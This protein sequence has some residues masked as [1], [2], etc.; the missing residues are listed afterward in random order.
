MDYVTGRPAVPRRVQTIRAY[1]VFQ[2]HEPEPTAGQRADKSCVRRPVS[3]AAPALEP[4][5]DKKTSRGGRAPG[6][7]CVQRQPCVGQHTLDRSRPFARRARRV[8]SWR[9][10]HRISETSAQSQ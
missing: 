1:R 5:R 6:R 9:D 8:G 2:A 10:A 3:R 4:G 7:V